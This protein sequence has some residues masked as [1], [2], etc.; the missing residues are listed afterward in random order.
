MASDLSL[1]VEQLEKN[2][3]QAFAGLTGG[4][5][6]QAYALFNSAMAAATLFGPVFGGWL[7]EGFGWPVATSALAALAFSGI[8][9]TVRKLGFFQ[10][11]Y[12]KY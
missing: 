4:P 12:K 1:V 7:M 5:Y 10:Q 9:P 2:D 3:Q 11:Q 6:A 8:L